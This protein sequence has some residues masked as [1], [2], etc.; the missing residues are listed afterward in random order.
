MKRRAL[1]LGVA[2]LLAAYAA[3]PLAAWAKDD[4]NQQFNPFSV[5]DTPG[6]ISQ[7]LFPAGEDNF[8][9]QPDLAP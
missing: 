5:N 4:D 1:T 3:A 9:P 6:E 7:G 8:T 2:L